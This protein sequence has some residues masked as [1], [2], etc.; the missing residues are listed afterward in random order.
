VDQAIR[1]AVSIEGLVPL[2][3][4]T[5]LA[6]TNANAVEAASLYLPAAS[7]VLDQLAGALENRKQQLTSGAAGD[8]EQLR[9]KIGDDLARLLTVLEEIGGRRAD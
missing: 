2:R 6:R 5:Q 9:Q 1:N 7:R 8:A 4:L 3:A